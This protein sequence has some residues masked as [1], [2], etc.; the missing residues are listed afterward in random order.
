MKNPMVYFIILAFITLSIGPKP[1]GAGGSTALIMNELFLPA[2][3]TKVLLTPAFIPPALKGIKIHPDNPLRFDFLINKSED[4]QSNSKDQYS[5]LVKYFLAA[6]TIP[7][8][9]MWVTY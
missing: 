9:D 5:K 7:E 1:V 8:K 6:L 3:G 4:E 2:P